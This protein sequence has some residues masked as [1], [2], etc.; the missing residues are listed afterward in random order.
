MEGGAVVRDGDVKKSVCNPDH[1]KQGLGFT[2]RYSV[3][4]GMKHTR[5][6]FNG[7]GPRLQQEANAKAAKLRKCVKGADVRIQFKC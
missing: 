1:A 3:H 6:W 2:F 4:E 7:D 5:D